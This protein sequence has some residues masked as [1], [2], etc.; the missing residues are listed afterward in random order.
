MKK[1]WLAIIFILPLSACKNIFKTD[2]NYQH[3]Y[4]AKGEYENKNGSF[5]NLFDRRGN[6]IGYYKIG[7]PYKVKGNTYFPHKYENY[8]KV[9]AAS[10]YGDYFNGKKTANGEI[11]DSHQVTAAHR[12]LPLPSI[13]RVTNLENGKVIMARVND[14]GPFLDDRIIDLSKESATLLGFKEKGIAK[15]KVELLPEE[16]KAL[17]E[18]LNIKTN[19][20]LQK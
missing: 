20:K 13:V 4:I 12:T 17:L 3:H 1:L 2:K 15:V 18:K 14:R 11:F 7:K 19:D 16:T 9:G 5:D 10:W 8:H 6:Y